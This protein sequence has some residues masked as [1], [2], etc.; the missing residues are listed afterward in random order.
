[1]K[2][3]MQIRKLRLVPH[4]RHARLHLH[5]GDR[6]EVLKVRPP[7]ENRNGRRL[8]ERL[9]IKVVQEIGSEFDSLQMER[10]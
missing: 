3:M 10:P 7:R 9:V 1:M 8:P 6:L 2:V 4:R 5:P